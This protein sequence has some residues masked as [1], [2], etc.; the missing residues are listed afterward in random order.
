MDDDTEMTPTEFWSD[1]PGGTM[2][3]ATGAVRITL[4]DEMFTVSDMEWSY[5]HEHQVGYLCVHHPPEGHVNAIR[6]VE[7]IPGRLNVDV[8][9]EDGAVLGVE[10]IGAPI[11]W[12]ELGLVLKWCTLGEQANPTVIPW[13]ED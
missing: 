7:I 4:G 11:G 2:T 3:A 8:R 5:S 10:C 13:D 1:F 12:H 6:T 9:C